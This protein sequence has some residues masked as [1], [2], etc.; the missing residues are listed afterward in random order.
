[1]ENNNGKR[2]A[3]ASAQRSGSTCPACCGFGWLIDY[4]ADPNSKGGTKVCHVCEGWG[5]I[6]SIEE[7]KYPAF[8]RSGCFVFSVSTVITI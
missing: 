3:T 1:M 4:D 8:T 2:D 5:W 6:V 7:V